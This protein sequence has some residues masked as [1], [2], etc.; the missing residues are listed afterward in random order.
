VIAY[1]G[2]QEWWKT[3]RHW[4][5]EE[6]GRVVDAIIAKGQKPTAYASYDLSKI[7]NQSDK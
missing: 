5:T 4:H 1:P 3:R 7:K 6:F 2:V